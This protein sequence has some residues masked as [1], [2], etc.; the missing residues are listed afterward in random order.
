M[1]SIVHLES[2]VLIRFEAAIR[3]G[4]VAFATKFLKQRE[5]RVDGENR[6]RNC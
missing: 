2:F 5:T 3:L 4:S 6:V 1:A